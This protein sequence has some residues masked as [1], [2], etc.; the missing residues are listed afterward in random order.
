M[1]EFYDAFQTSELERW[2]AI[3]A[4]DVMTNS[5][6]SFGNI[7]FEAPKGWARGSL[8]AFAPRTDLADEIDAINDAGDFVGLNPSSRTGTAV[9]NLILTVRSGRVT[10][11]EVADTP[12]N[13]AAYVHERGWVFPQVMRPVPIVR[14]IDRDTEKNPVDLR[15]ESRSN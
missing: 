6:A 10:R 14:G 8:T 1:R 5:S 9:E 15:P 12:L 13:L 7:G 3:V 4:P 11:I 2:G